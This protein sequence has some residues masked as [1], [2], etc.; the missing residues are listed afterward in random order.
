MPQD[1]VYRTR[2][3]TTR[4]RWGVVVF[5]AVSLTTIGLFIYGLLLL[6]KDFY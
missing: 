3:L 5:A 4:E 1:Y 6:V 2:V